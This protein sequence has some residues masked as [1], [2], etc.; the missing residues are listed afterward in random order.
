[1]RVVCNADELHRPGYLLVLIGL[2][3]L[4][5]K[6]QDFS[7]VGVVLHRAKELPDL[8]GFWSTGEQFLAQQTDLFLQVRNSLFKR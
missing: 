4:P 6:L 8:T 5:P 1:M 3:D 7:E 2:T